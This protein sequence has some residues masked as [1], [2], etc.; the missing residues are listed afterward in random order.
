MAGM[1]LQ[2]SKVTKITP[3]KEQEITKGNTIG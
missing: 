3:D 2:G 1:G